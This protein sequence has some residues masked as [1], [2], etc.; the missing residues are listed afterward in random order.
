VQ[1]R[2]AA[3]QK[4]N[5]TADSWNS[6]VDVG[7]MPRFQY[8]EEALSAR[9]KGTLWPFAIMMMMN[10]VVFSAAYISFVKYDVR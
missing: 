8:K 10:L 4:Q 7:D 6:P 3:L 5:P 2:I 1:G 9:A